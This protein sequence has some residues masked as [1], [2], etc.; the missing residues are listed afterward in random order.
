[1]KV[2][3]DGGRAAFA[4][5]ERVEGLASWELQEPPA[6]LEVRLFWCTSGR[7]TED[8]SVV[9]VEAV[10]APAASGWVRFSFALP[11]GPYSFSGRLVSLGWAVE[12]VAPREKVAASASI[13]V[14]PEGREAR[15]DGEP[16]ADAEASGAT[17]AKG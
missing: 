14:G 11:P 3:I 4:P 10:P 12:L 17:G 9:A 2:E 13:V 7:G 1:M 8:Q 15:I 6:E 5:G 16:P